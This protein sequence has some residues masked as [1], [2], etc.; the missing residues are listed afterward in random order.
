MAEVEY[1]T[2]T[3]LPVESIWEFVKEMDNWA[4]FIT[5]Y[6][7]HEKESEADSLW[8][9]KGDVGVLQRRVQFRAHV[10]EWSGPE[11]VCFELEGVNEQLTG[12]GSFTIG[13]YEEAEASPGAPRKGLLARLA[14]A[15]L[16][17][18]QRLIHGR[19]E[20]GADADAGPGEGMAKLTFEL[21]IE[22]GG[23]M[24]PMISAMMQPALGVAA[25][26]LANKIIAH[27]EAKRDGQ[28]APA[29]SS[30]RS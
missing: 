6:Q 8:T 15:V 28:A 4:P 16:R 24:A 17:F 18:F 14:E 21:R 20:R 29:Y 7:G 13:R 30:E 23:P 2:T 9:L 26:D 1:S 22:P 25:E 27:L 10:T 12:S 19:I 3:R 5:G 11:R